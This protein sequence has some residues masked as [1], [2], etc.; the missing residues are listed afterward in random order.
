MFKDAP[1]RYNL[2]ATIWSSALL[3]EHTTPA[4]EG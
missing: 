1:K 3:A 4:L 2:Q